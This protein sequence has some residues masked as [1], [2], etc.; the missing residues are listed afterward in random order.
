[1]SDA[2][3]CGRC[4]QK[5]RHLEH[6]RTDPVLGKVHEGPC[7]YVDPLT[8]IRGTMAD[9]NRISRSMASAEIR[10]RARL[11]EDLGVPVSAIDV[12]DRRIEIR[13]DWEPDEDRKASVVSAIEREF[14]GWTA[15]ISVVDYP[16]FPDGF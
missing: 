14:R 6:Y 5:W 9:L 13:C 10:A 16:R 11:A 1:M 7:P 4:R 3:R 12:T 2:S 15:A 8:A